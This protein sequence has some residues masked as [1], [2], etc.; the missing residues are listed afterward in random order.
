ME[1]AVQEELNRNIPTAEAFRNL[2][3][4]LANLCRIN[5][6]FL[7]SNKRFYVSMG[8][9]CFFATPLCMRIYLNF[10]NKQHRFN[11][12]ILHCKKCTARQ[13]KMFG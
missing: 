11:T 8:L 9:A 6:Y 5:L 3:G 12:G 7:N 10:Q 4:G 1:T 13:I 2:S